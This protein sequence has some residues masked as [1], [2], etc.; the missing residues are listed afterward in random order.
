MEN[1]GTQQAQAGDFAGLFHAAAT[2]QADPKRPSQHRVRQGSR[3][4]KYNA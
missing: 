2:G 1:Q 3:R 4:V